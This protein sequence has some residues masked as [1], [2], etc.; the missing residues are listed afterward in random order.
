MRIGAERRSAAR[1]KKRNGVG[2]EA[3]DRA[4]ER[5]RA[6]QVGVIDFRA[7]VEQQ[8]DDVV[9]SASRGVVERRG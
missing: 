3:V 2:S 7:P 9:V 1:H 8:P 4:G 5:R 6:V